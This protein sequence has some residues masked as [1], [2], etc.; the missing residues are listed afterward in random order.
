MVFCPLLYIIF[1]SFFAPVRCGAVGLVGFAW[2]LFGGDSRSSTF[3]FERI[4][5]CVWEKAE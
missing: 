2:G 5:E 1:V 3:W 4:K